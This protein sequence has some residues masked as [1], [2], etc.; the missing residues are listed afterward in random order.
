MIKSL[1]YPQLDPKAILSSLDHITLTEDEEIQGLI[2]AKQRKQEMLRQQEVQ[3]RE[4][5]NR[6]LLTGMQWS[7]EQTKSFMLY[8]SEEQFQGKF[9][10][11][12]FNRATFELLCYY[13]SA[14]PNFISMAEGMGI[15]NPSLDKG[16][17]LRGATGAGKTWLMRLFARNQRQCFR[18]FNAKKVADSFSSNEDENQL[19][20]FIQKTK[21]PL[22]DKEMFMQKHA[23]LCID[24]IGTEDIK[25]HYGNKRNVI[26]DVIELRYSA[27]NCGVIFHA[28]TN[29]KNE[30]LSDYYGAR[31]MDRMK[32]VWNFITISGTSRRK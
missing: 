18:M 22:N 15:K 29:L 17:F 5:E 20:Q 16:L 1:S 3:Q 24:D 32:E 13:F 31:A 12:D 10:I 19:D 9:Q 23:G 26:A 25:T 27:G 14:D 2:W 28:T 21:N 7:Y 30:E 11:D 8:R 6:R 4:V